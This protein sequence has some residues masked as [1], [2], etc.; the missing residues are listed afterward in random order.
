[1]NNLLE[2]ITWNK[3]IEVLRT[4]KGWTQLET[5]EKC[6]TTQKVYW[7]WET[8]NAYPRKN[9]RTAIA[10][11]FDVSEDEIFKDIEVDSGC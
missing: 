5:A 4:I 6:N 1:M 8:G 7:S 11:A 9:S 10:K 3:K 2:G